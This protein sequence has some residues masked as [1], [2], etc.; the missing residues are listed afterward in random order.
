MVAAAARLR[1]TGDTPI[2][3]ALTRAADDLA[4]G[5]ASRR[6][7]V[8]ISD[9]EDNCSAPGSSPCQV[10]RGLDDSGV[11]VRVESVGVALAGK[12]AAQDALRCVAARSGGSYYDAEDADALSAALQRISSDALG[13]ARPGH[14]RCR[15]RAPAGTP[16]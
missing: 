13:R 7:V 8:L 11:K 12:A 15:A 3:L 1:P 2:G 5:T 9:G 10:V 4:G 6:V 14:G 16:G